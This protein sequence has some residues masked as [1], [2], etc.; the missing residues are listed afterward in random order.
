MSYLTYV[1]TCE[2]RGCLPYVEGEK[3]IRQYKES[4]KHCH[5]HISTAASAEI[6]TSYIHHKDREKQKCKSQWRRK[7]PS[8][9]KMHAAQNTLP[10]LKVRMNHG[11]KCTC[12][13]R[14]VCQKKKKW[15]RG[16]DS[17]VPSGCLKF[18]NHKLR[19]SGQCMY[20]V[21]SQKG[22]RQLTPQLFELMLSSMLQTSRFP[23][24]LRAHSISHKRAQ[25]CKRFNL[26]DIDTHAISLSTFDM[27]TRTQHRAYALTSTLVTMDMVKW[28]CIHN[29]RHVRPDTVYEL[30]NANGLK[31]C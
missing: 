20:T 26:P 22:V 3:E 27:H 25:I 14:D 1:H 28:H 24:N 31:F 11:K 6:N 2:R 16:C 5:A 30:R 19:I 12:K 7:H 8:L 4:E 9:L 23:S 29:I 21:L 18:A 15:G 17:P 13:C 10:S